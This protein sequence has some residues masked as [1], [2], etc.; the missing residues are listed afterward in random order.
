MTRSNFTVFF[1]L[2]VTFAFAARLY[3][4][5]ELK[6]N[7]SNDE[8]VTYLSA[9]GN[10]VAYANLAN[11]DSSYMNIITKTTIWKDC[12]ISNP[13]FCFKKIAQG[14]SRYDIHPPLYFWIMHFF[15]LFFGLHTYTGLILNLIISLFMLFA[16]FKL[17]NYIF[18]NSEKALLVCLVWYLSPAVV[19]M[20]LEARHYQLF[21]LFAVLVSHISLMVLKENK[22]TKR[23]AILLILYSTLGL[24]THYY[25]PF[26]IGGI[27]IL[28]LIR[29][30]FSK[31]VIKILF[32][33]IAS[34]CCFLLL[35]PQFI[36][37]IQNYFLLKKGS[38]KFDIPQSIT[39]KVKTQLYAALDFGSSGHYMKYLYLL[40]LLIFSFAVVIGPSL[41]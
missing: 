7:F 41:V 35:F 39:D 3:A 26:V 36:D 19:Q 27:F 2:L 33:F 9:A 28:L 31:I 10:P 15:F 30:K 16:L 24:L 20:D 1:I 38:H 34:F 25:F 4:V 29:L 8:S 17:A 22:L 12:Y 14:M 18:N 40:A 32:A 13:P 5:F 23:N 11:P 21:A 37:F 6:H